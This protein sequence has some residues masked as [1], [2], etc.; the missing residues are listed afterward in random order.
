MQGLQQQYVQPFRPHR[1]TS[2]RAA[3]VLVRCAA[4][5]P[6]VVVT[7]EHGK[8]GKLIKALSKH[9]IQCVELPLIEHAP[10]PDR[11]QLPGLL[12]AGAFDW[13][14]CTSPESAAVF[15]EGWKAAGSPQVRVAVVGGG[16]GEVLAAAGVNPEF[17]ATKALGKVMGSELP[18][19][20]GGSDVVLY[21][22]SVKAS[23]DLQDSLAAAGFSVQRINTY[24]TVSGAALPRDPLARVDDS[25]SVCCGS[26]GPHLV[27]MS[28]WM[29]SRELA[30]AAAAGR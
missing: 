12:Q 26:L 23:T 19:V 6:T 25:D 7:R 2:S 1:H 18:H 11:D 24:N 8:N 5:S 16:T 27:A 4:G 14:T 30:P 13:V 20:P 17:T 22:A 15:V 21:P 9:G 3:A 10:G 29:N 28:R